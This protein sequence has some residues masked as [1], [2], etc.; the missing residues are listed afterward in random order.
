MTDSRDLAP[1]EVFVDILQVFLKFLQGFSLGDAVG[2]LLNVAKPNILVLPVHISY[3][4]HVPI[5]LPLIVRFNNS[6][7]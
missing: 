4:F 7:A 5:L 1:G 2:K 6:F 3:S